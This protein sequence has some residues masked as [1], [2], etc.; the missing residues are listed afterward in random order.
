MTSAAATGTKPA[1]DQRVDFYRGIALAMIFIN[2]I[3]GVI[4]ENYTSRNFGFSDA[5]ELF[6]FLAGFASAFAYARPFLAGTRLRTGLKAWRRAGV[7]YLVHIMLTMFAIGSFCWAALAFGRGDLL[8]HF[9]LELFIAKP[10]EALVG[11]ITLSH[12]LGYVNILPMYSVILLMLPLMLLLVRFVGRNG[13][14]A[15][16][17]V[18]WVLTGLLK[19][20]IPNFPYEG[21]WFFN[22]FAWQFVF[23]IGLWCGL[24]KWQRGY[25]VPYNRFLYAAAVV[26][27]IGAFIFVGLDA[28]GSERAL[29]MPFLLTYFDKTFVT[30]P[31]LLHVLALIYVFAHAPAAS[32][33]QKIGSN[34]LFTRLGRHSLPI[35]AA[36]TVLSLVAQII[37]FG[38]PPSFLLDTLL[39]LVGLALQVFLA[40]YLDWWKKKKTSL[41][42]QRDAAER[43]VVQAPPSL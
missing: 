20:N 42:P 31:R 4:W 30:V 1:R 37:Y 17:A 34:N 5:A 13:M 22:P 18:F 12:Q 26:Y 41:P 6:V 35:F 9:G 27:L 32:P 19:L 2:H 16:A 14:L 36:G 21:G 24:A 29:G 11:V 15:V 3:P 10:I 28:W 40:I 33:L 23:A 43:H 39:V 7:L 38:N 25:A 8:Q